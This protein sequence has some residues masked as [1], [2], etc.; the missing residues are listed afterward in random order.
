MMAAAVGD[1]RPAA[2]SEQKI[3]KSGDSIPALSLAQNPDIL[4]NVSQQTHCPRLTVGF[5]AESQDLVE[6]AQS[7]LT[8]KKLDLI[9]ANDISASDAGIPTG[10][11]SSRV[12]RWRGYRW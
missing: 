4:L 5:A 3:K 9:V 7:K 10:Y 12:I 11:C 1:F 6:N 8:H 2:V